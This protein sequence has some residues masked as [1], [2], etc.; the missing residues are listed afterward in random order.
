MNI[1]LFEQAYYHPL[2]T[3]EDLGQVI[4]AHERVEFKKSDF[5]LRKGDKADEYYLLE[6]GLIR[7]FVY[8]PDGEDITTNFVTSGEF[9][10][11][12]SSLFQRISTQENIQ[13]LTDCVCWKIGFEA[14]QTLFHSMDSMAEWGRA[15]MSNS[16]FFF[17]QRSLDMITKSAKERYIELI[18]QKPLVIQQAPL[19]T[20]ATYLGITGTSLSR[21]RKDIVKN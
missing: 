16:L 21:I 7:S 5:L 13:T 9:A 4:D 20:I 2:I 14:F 8:N 11:E 18:T 12:V 3:K 15:W 1:Q 19:K 17:K 10:I 6:S